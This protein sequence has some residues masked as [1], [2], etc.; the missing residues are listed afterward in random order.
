MQ[1][2]VDEFVRAYVARRCWRFGHALPVDDRFPEPPWE[3]DFVVLGQTELRRS[4]EVG[5]RLDDD[6]RLRGVAH[7]VADVG[8]QLFERLFGGLSLRWLRVGL[9][10][11]GVAPSSLEQRL[12]DG[13]QLRDRWEISATVVCSVSASNW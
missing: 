11:F 10:D 9:F 8:E 2:A 12:G 7:P 6:E 4:F 5:Q 13:Q 1:Q 3:R